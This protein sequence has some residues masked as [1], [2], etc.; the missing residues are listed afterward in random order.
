MDVEDVSGF[1]QYITM[2][3]QQKKTL[4]AASKRKGERPKDRIP[5]AKA[6]NDQ[7]EHSIS[8]K[9]MQFGRQ[10]SGNILMHS[11]F[12]AP[13]YL[14]STASLKDLDPVYIKDLQ[15]ET[16]HRGFYL[17]LRV[18]T[19]PV[20]MTAIMVVM[21]DENED[22]MLVQIYQQQDEE[23]RAAEDI[24]RDKAVCV[25]KEPYF[26][27]MGDGKYG[28]RIDHIT[29]LTWLPHDD[30]KVPLAWRPRFQE[31]EKTADK[32]RQE[33]NAAVKSG[34]FSEAVS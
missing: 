6:I 19:L 2:I 34:D 22:A 25:I 9:M 33:G 3:E 26:K 32:W 24:V 16:H 5:R 21:D 28:I 14:P 17:I 10:A 31:V 4:Q 1:H 11:S 29:D 30:E 15:L 13:P 27:V 12:L 23:E 7:N 8:T 20:R 18:V